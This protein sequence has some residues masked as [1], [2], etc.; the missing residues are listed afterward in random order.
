MPD[1]PEMELAL[2]EEEVEQ[3]RRAPLYLA[4]LAQ[5]IAVEVDAAGKVGRPFVAL[6]GVTVTGPGL[7]PFRIGLDRVN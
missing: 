4:G 7:P 1:A 6:C 5:A 2:T 3:L